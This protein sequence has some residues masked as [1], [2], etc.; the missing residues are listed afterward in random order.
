MI[1]VIPLWVFLLLAVAV[2]GGLAYATFV[3]ALLAP[4]M[5][6]LLLGTIAVGGVVGLIQAAIGGGV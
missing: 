5:F 2:V 3:A 4:W 6:W 1:E